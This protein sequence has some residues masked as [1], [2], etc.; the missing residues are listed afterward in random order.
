MVGDGGDGGVFTTE[1]AIRVFGEF[2]GPE[3]GLEGIV[4]S[5]FAEGRV[6]SLEDEFD[7][8]HGLE[9]ADNARKD[10]EDSSFCAVWDGTRWRA[11]G[12][13]ATVTRAAEVGCEDGHLPIEAV[14][15]AVDKGFFEEDGGIVCEETSGEIIRAIEDDIVVSG[16]GDGVFRGEADGM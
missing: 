2:D 16:D 15:G 14:D 10:P 5:D 7:G 1:F 8:L 11:F 6:A 13:E 9:G 4:D 3:A 12:Q